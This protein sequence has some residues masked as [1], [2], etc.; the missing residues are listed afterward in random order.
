MNPVRR[1]YDPDALPREFDSRSRWSR[2]I[3][4]NISG[5]HD[6]GWCG[7]SWAVS[8]ADVASDRFAIMSKGA[9]KVE[10][11]AQHLL[12]CNNRGQQG[13]RG[14]YLDRAWLFMRKFG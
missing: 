3:S 13:C 8:T 2:D 9:E 10:L 12:S 4:G 6:Q 7:A 1:I 11:S 5:I 14:G